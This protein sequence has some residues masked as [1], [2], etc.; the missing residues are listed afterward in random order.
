MVDVTWRAKS[1]GSED[2]L[3]D[4]SRTPCVHDY[5]VY[6]WKF[7]FFFHLPDS[8]DNTYIQS[9]GSELRQSPWVT[10]SPPR[11]R[12]A[13]VTEQRTTTRSG[14]PARRS[15]SKPCVTAI[16]RYCAEESQPSWMGS[17]PGSRRGTEDRTQAGWLQTHLGSLGTDPANA[18]TKIAILRHCRRTPQAILSDQRYPWR[19]PCPSTTTT[20][21][22]KS[23]RSSASA[24]SAQPEKHRER[25]SDN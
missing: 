4:S 12:L 9:R 5:V 18:H 3:F 13:T 10:R 17:K 15:A 22:P 1:A 20:S 19:T 25:I 11:A 7:R 2:I 24:E 21:P 14:T 6:I 16:V 8:A 23:N